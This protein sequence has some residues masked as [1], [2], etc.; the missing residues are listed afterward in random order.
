MEILQLSAFVSLA[1]TLYMPLTAQEL[2]T[3]QSHISKLIGSLEAELGVKLF[4]RI[5]RRIILNEHGK[6]FLNMHLTR[7]S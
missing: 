1:K 5:G 6:L 2:N 3:S 7:C 4:D